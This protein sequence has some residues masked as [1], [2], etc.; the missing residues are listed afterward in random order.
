MRY[1]EGV[2]G[3]IGAV[4]LAHLLLQALEMEHRDLHWSNVLVRRT[5]DQHLLFRLEGKEHLI[6]S[7]GVK[8]TVVDY[9]LSR[10][11]QGGHG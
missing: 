2:P 7:H 5:A 3:L 10:M 1:W 11:K 9:T 8:A 4:P 6:P